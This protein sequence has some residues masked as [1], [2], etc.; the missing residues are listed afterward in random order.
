MCQCCVKVSHVFHYQTYKSNNE[1]GDCAKQTLRA[2]YHSELCNT[3]WKW[4]PHLQLAQDMCKF[5]ICLRAAYI[6]SR[7]AIP[8]SK[9]NFA[10]LWCCVRGITSGT[11]SA[12]LN[13]TRVCLHQMRD[14]KDWRRPQPIVKHE[15]CATGYTTN[16][17]PQD[18]E[19]ALG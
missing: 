11:K 13:Q 3:V 2:G 16:A 9:G 7:C 1:T 12:T 4:I 18:C 19:V 15:L 17:A 10:I 14:G 6:I 8:L 5:G